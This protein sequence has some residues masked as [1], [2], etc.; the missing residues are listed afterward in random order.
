MGEW[1]EYWVVDARNPVTGHCRMGTGYTAD[2]AT[3]E[4]LESIRKA[5]S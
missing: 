3:A 2:E 5:N 1:E 4:C